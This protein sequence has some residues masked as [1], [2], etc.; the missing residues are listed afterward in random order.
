M[1]LFSKL[2]LV[3]LWF[4]LIGPLHAQ[5]DQAGAVVQINTR[6]G[7]TVPVFELWNNNAVATVVLFS[8]G[9]GGYGK[10]GVDGWPASKNFLIRTGKLWAAHAFNIVMV[11]RPSDGIDLHDGAVRVGDEH[12]ADNVAVFKA[13]KNKSPLPMWVV[14]TSMGSIS[15][16]SAAIHDADNLVAGVV[17]TSSVTAYRIRGAVPGQELAKIRVPVLVVHHARDA[18]KSCTPYEAKNIPS[19]LTNSP[20]KEMVLIEAGSAPSGDPCEPMHYPG[21]IGAEPEVGALIASW[22]AKAN[23][24]LRPR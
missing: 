24:E 7:V 22:I 15:A 13:I 3:A 9:A 5:A 10:I 8:G 11:G 20:R 1:A 21:Y 19:A 4:S 2:A 6:P 14:G 18:C 17:L 16:A 23:P 12:G